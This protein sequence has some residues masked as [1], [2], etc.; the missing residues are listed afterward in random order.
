MVAFSVL[1]YTTQF[2]RIERSK[3]AIQCIHH[4]WM[5]ELIQ[6]QWAIFGDREV[7]IT[8]E[9]EG[10]FVKTTI[11][12]EGAVY[13]DVMPF[14]EKDDIKRSLYRAAFN[15]RPWD[16]PWGILTGI[17]PAKLAF[18]NFDKAS[19]MKKYFVN[20]RQA[21]LC[22]EVAAFTKTVKVTKEDISLY[23]HIPFCRTKCAYCS[24]VTNAIDR[25]NRHQTKYIDCLIDEIKAIAPTIAHR[26]LRS[27]Y[28]G[29]GTP[30]VLDEGNLSRLLS[31]IDTH[32][33]KEHLLEFTVEAG[34]VDTITEEK[35]RLLRQANVNRI[36]INPQVF[37]NEILAK[38]GRTH[39][40]ED[41]IRTYH[42]AR[43][44]G[45]QTINM[46]IIYGLGGDFQ[47]T[48]DTLL[49]LDPE[50]IT[51]HTLAIK[52]G[53]NL[54]KDYT[55]N[56]GD[57]NYFYQ[58]ITHRPYYLYRQQYMIKPY[59]NV[60]FCKEGSACL[61]N[62]YM[63]ENLMDILALGSGSTTKMCSERH[64]NNKYPLDYINN[65]N[66]ILQKKQRFLEQFM[67]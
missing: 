11:H 31:A 50:N 56:L 34:R 27:I 46:D 26:K 21:L 22:Q 48:V 64:F 51:L 53:S 36:S 30:T 57:I 67:K 28:I 23:I 5:K 49:A 15:I 14:T 12:F 32:F 18:V 10:D 6:M 45:F 37:D 39:T 19:F 65:I 1:Y 42:K 25:T 24:F 33:L 3:M 2:I 38:I 55:T 16:T 54:S 35:L 58:N 13:S 52:R 29:G 41:V 7:E 62:V 20:E 43:E 44:I 8:S 17:N 9:L 63:M 66:E 59:E 61:Y 47:K 60:G 40:V 4:Q